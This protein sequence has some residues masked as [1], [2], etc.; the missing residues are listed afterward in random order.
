ML[1]LSVRG[2][3]AVVAQKFSAQIIYQTRRRK[4]N[5]KRDTMGEQCQIVN[6]I[7][8]DGYQSMPFVCLSW[9]QMYFVRP[10]ISDFDSPTR[11]TSHRIHVSHDKSQIYWKQTNV[12]SAN[13]SA[14]ST[15]SIHSIIHS[16]F[17]ALAA[18]AASAV[19]VLLVCAHAAAAAAT[20]QFGIHISGGCARVHFNDAVCYRRMMIV[21]L[22]QIE[23]MRKRG[24]FTTTLRVE[25]HLNNA[26]NH[27]TKSNQKL[28]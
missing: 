14:C 12:E 6:A 2:V 3:R 11:I 22:L 25:V 4:S 1:M 28:I 23:M 15:R 21:L 10:L 5:R 19:A 24:A 20:A 9:H 16:F 26:K 18:A 27:L 8:D 7:N 13:I 17:Y